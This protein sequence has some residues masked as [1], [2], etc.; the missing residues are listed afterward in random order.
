MIDSLTPKLSCG[1]DGISYRLIKTFKP[2]LLETMTDITNESKVKGVFPKPWKISK[3]A[4]IWKGKGSKQSVDSYRPVS[5]TSCVGKIVE[6]VIVGQM[7]RTLEC[8]GILPQEMHGFRPG[9]STATAITNV[10]ESVKDHL[11][12]KKY[13]MAVA[14]DASAAFDIMPRDFLVTSVERIGGGPRICAWLE[15]YLHDR[16]SYV[17]VGEH[18]SEE[19]ETN[20]GVIQ[21]GLMSPIL[22][23]V[24]SITLPSWN[25]ESESVVYADDDFELV[26]GDT[27]E[28]CQERGQAAAEKVKD[29]FNHVGLCL[30]AK[31]SEMMGFGFSPWPIKIG[32]D[33]IQPSHS[34]KFLGCHIQSDLKWDEQVSAVAG[35]VR[36]AAGRIRYEGQLMEMRDRRTLYHGW[37]SGNIMASG[38]A[39]LPLI[40]DTQTQELQRAC[41]SGVRA[42]AGLPRGGNYPL[43]KTRKAIGIASVEEVKETIVL[44]EAWKRRPSL[45]KDPKTR[46][47]HKGNIKLPS[48]KGWSGKLMDTRAKEAWN[49]LP[50]HIRNEQSEQKMKKLVKQHIKKKRE[51]E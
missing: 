26:V 20:T 43:T 31:K 17:Q 50:S 35:K 4:P 7:T 2:E 34:V 29:W 32:T 47:Q 11:L 25:R 22:Y 45:N 30:N 13:V 9:R 12:K 41:N 8:L 37:I 48:L 23:N 18:R 46:S 1:P 21:G 16:T 14:L 27:P 44:E 28:E 49:R 33:T 10:V 3:V 19:W 24:G 15:N 42:V 5:L 39:Y 40:T 51:T 6:S 36:S 38:R